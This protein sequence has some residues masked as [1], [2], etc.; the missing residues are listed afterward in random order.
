MDV[1]KHGHSAVSHPVIVGRSI[2][3]EGHNMGIMRKR[4][5]KLEPNYTLIG[6]TA[7][8]LPS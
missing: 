1:D 2:T 5:V 7:V 8:T 3:H 6:A 4:Y